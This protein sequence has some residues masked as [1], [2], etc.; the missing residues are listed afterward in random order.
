MIDYLQEYNFDKKLENTWKDKIKQKI[1]ISSVNP[2]R[3]QKR[4]VEFVNNYVLK[5]N[6]GDFDNVTKKRFIN[7]LIKDL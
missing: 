1:Q 3:Y 4:F 2:E 7:N 5:S 6:S